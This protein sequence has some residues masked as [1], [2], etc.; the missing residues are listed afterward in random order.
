MCQDFVLLACCASFYVVCN[1]FLHF[2]PP[3]FFLCFLES[4]VVAWVSSRW[5]VMHEGYDAPFYFED[6]W[7]NDLSFVICCNGCC[8]EFVLWK[9]RNILVVG[10]SFVGTRRA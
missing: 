2:G 1:P 5:V 10:F 4:F 7:Y 9:Y 3:V 6:W 8:D